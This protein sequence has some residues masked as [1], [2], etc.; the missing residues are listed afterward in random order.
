MEELYVRTEKIIYRNL[1]NSWSVIR[2]FLPSEKQ[3]VTVTGIFADIQPGMSL[4]LS[5]IWQE[6]ER[7]GRQFRAEHYEYAEDASRRAW[8][9][10]DLF[11]RLQ[12]SSFRMR[13]H[14]KE[15]DLAYIKEKGID[16]VR[17]HAEEIIRKR[18]TPAVIPNDGKQTPMRG[19]PHGH[20]VFL[21]QHA[22]GT[23]CRGCLA[24]WHGIPAGRELT[25]EEIMYITDVIMKWIVRENIQQE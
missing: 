19:A 24:K 16:T 6:T 17:S 22:T 23:C 7:Y 2:C 13:F 8:L 3:S 14:L 15:A 21:A 11:E 10:R 25:E 12:E 4:K 18:L 5:G 9:S 20:P 1:Q